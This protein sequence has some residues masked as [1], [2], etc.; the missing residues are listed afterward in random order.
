MIKK[1]NR[2]GWLIMLW[3]L[4]ILSKSQILINEVMFNPEGSEQTDEFV[5]IIHIGNG[6]PISLSGW[7]LSDGKSMDAI[8]DAGDGLIL[9]PGQIGLILDPDYFEQSSF[10]DEIIPEETPIFTIAGST[11]GQGGFSNSSPEPVLL[12]DSQ[13]FRADS[14]CYPVN[15]KPGYS[16]EKI[17]AE[18]QMFQ[19]SNWKE[20]KLIHGTPGAKNSVIPLDVDGAILGYDFIRTPAGETFDFTFY[21]NVINMGQLPIQA[22]TVV[23]LTPNNGDNE[24]PQEK[25]SQK[26]DRIESG[27]SMWVQLSWHASQAGTYD[28]TIE[29][30]VDSDQELENNTTQFQLSVPYLAGTLVLNEIMAWPASGSPEWIEIYNPS[31]FKVDMNGWTLTDS[32]TSQHYVISDR[33]LIISPGTYLVVSDQDI[34]LEDTNPMMAVMDEFPVLNNQHDAVFLY[35]PSGT[36]IDQVNYSSFWGLEPGLSLERIRWESNTQDSTNWHHCTLLSGGTPGYQNSVNEP[37]WIGPSELLAAPDPFFP[38]R[39]GPQNNTVIHYVIPYDYAMVRVALF[40]IQGRK[41][42]DLRTGQESSHDG[43][44]I[45]DG[46][47]N[48]GRMARTGIYLI[49]LE[50]MDYKTGTTYQK[51]ATVVLAGL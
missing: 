40:D 47:D 18:N 24:S 12:F 46:R 13:N 32:D 39:P 17:M 2:L 5:E 23:C 44:L 25:Y 7:R 36:P 34:H 10:Y 37:D 20:S 27:D 50:A 3:V 30:R 22:E 51:K 42:R 26:I 31:V 16:Y 28:V 1:P 41:I 15:L 8:T 21:L 14:I 29:I 6:G 45:W 38:N 49:T 48:Y 43:L 4:S 11:F 33:P 19:E 35:D 9:Q